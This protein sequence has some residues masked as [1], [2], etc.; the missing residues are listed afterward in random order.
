MPGNPG[1]GTGG[2][3]HPE[4]R[5]LEGH[6]LQ[7]PSKSLRL[8]LQGCIRLSCL[9]GVLNRP[10][11]LAAQ[12]HHLLVDVLR[13]GRTPRA[14]PHP[15]LLELRVEP[16]VLRAQPH[17][18]VV[19]LHLGRADL[20]LRLLFEGLELALVLRA[21]D[22]ALGLDPLGVQHLED[23]VERP[24]VLHQVAAK[25][26]D[27]GRERAVLLLELCLGSHQLLRLLPPRCLGSHRSRH[28]ILAVSTATAAA[29]FCRAVEAQQ[30]ATGL[31]KLGAGRC[32][33]GGLAGSA[34]LGLGASGSK[35]G[36]QGG[37]ARLGLV[38]LP[39]GLLELAFEDVHLLVGPLP[40]LLHHPHLMLQSGRLRS[41]RFQAHLVILL[42]PLLLLLNIPHARFELCGMHAHSLVELPE[43]PVLARPTLL[44][45]LH[46]PIPLVLRLLHAR[47]QRRR[48]GAQPLDLR[49]ALL[50]AELHSG[51]AAGAIDADR[52]PQ[53]GVGALERSSCSRGS[54][55]LAH[56]L[57]HAFLQRSTRA[58]SGGQGDRA[59][60]FVL[61][62]QVM[63]SRHQCRRLPPRGWARPRRRP[64]HNHSP[65]AGA[66]CLGRGRLERGGKAV[67]LGSELPIALFQPGQARLEARRHSRC[68]RR[69]NVL[70]VSNAPRRRCGTRI[71][72]VGRC[73]AALRGSG[74]C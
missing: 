66:G 12:P 68:H 41:H 2:G 52:R 19:G 34:R 50:E 13:G 29:P 30:L 14:P 35:L 21:V 69:C 58:P 24:L 65:A 43:H 53:C 55:P 5:E 54:V 4:G 1:G 18:A 64:V 6:A 67:E 31:V 37:G 33:L 45:A 39:D 51:E 74:G 60:V 56:Q 10:M 26:L 28:W 63:H 7:L 70:E 9:R 17:Q 25:L 72:S 59:E 62:L 73:D 11:T 49:G 15:E 44:G 71:R 32:E 42:S 48:V 61:R 8:A 36:S 27:L 40:L 22:H 3:L 38:P 23:L 16:S 57:L 20:P 47:L 46:S